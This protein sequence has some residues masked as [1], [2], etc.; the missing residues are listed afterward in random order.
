MRDS[1]LPQAP[2]QQANGI[3]SKKREVLDSVVVRF[4]GDSGDGM[5]TAG[6]QFGIE[7]ALSG[8]DISTFPDFP[9]E[10]RGRQ[11]PRTGFR[12]FRSTSDRRT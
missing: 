8:K 2:G 4:A 5:Q 1:K 10:I 12:P 3:V 9:A 11:A 6:A 7:A